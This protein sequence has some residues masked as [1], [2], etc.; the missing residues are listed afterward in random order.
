MSRVARAEPWA[1]FTQG[2]SDLCGDTAAPK[3]TNMDRS[4]EQL[5]HLLRTQVHQLEA[6]GGVLPGLNAQL[7]ELQAGMV[8]LK[9]EMQSVK[10]EI[11]VLLASIESVRE[12]QTVVERRQQRAVSALFGEDAAPRRRSGSVPSA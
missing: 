9:V 12:G 6:L 10:S 2:A 4:M 3:P 1:M 8:D 5:P 7:K 11:G